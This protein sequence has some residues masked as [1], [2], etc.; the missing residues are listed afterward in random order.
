M[1]HNKKYNPVATE[2]NVTPVNKAGTEDFEIGIRNSF[3]TTI[4][5]VSKSISISVMGG[6]GTSGWIGGGF[7][8]VSFGL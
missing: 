1:Y 2:P 7:G 4:S 8:C 6:G 3:T 5:V